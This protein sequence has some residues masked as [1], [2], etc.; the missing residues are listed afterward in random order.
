MQIKTA[1]PPHIY[2]DDMILPK[3]KDRISIY[4]PIP[5]SE[6]SKAETQIGTCIPTFITI[7]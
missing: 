7:I 3:V 1:R 2:W 5:Y 4:F 6:E